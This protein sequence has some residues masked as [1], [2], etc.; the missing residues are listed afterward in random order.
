MPCY[1]DTA[2]PD[3]PAAGYAVCAS[4]VSVAQWLLGNHRATA[5]PPR[6]PGQLGPPA[7]ARAQLGESG[8]ASGA[9]PRPVGEWPV[10][11]GAF[12][13]AAWLCCNRSATLSPRG[14]GRGRRS[15]ARAIG[16]AGELSGAAGGAGRRATGAWSTPGGGRAPHPAGV[17]ASRRAAAGGADGAIRRA[18]RARRPPSAP[19]VKRHGPSRSRPGA[20]RA[21]ASDPVARRLAAA[22]GDR[23]FWRTS[24]RKGM[25][26]DGRT[27]RRSRTFRLFR[28]GF[29]MNSGVAT[30]QNC[31]GTCIA[32][33]CDANVRSPRRWCRA[34]T[35]RRSWSARG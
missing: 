31:N 21:T 12:R 33:R 27:A 14:A 13:V 35:R 2:P 19:S 1:R 29:R 11:G 25:H 6:G 23:V 32:R 22:S 10:V 18:R 24:V 5:R 20:Q 26:P 15:G 9:A 7:A 8:C 3:L 4:T 28:H 34:R 30:G 16:A 17:R